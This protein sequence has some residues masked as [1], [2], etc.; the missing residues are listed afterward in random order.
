MT[1]QPKRLAALVGQLASRPGHETV[2][3]LTNELCVVGLDVPTQEVSFEVRIPEVR[4]RM[5]ALFGS[6]VF[7]FKRDLRKEKDDAEEQLARYISER[8]SS[9]KR[10]YLGIAT[11]GADFVAYQLTE[12]KL[13]RL[14]DFQSNAN[15]PRALLQWLDTAITVRGD[16]P[17]DTIT[18]RREFG[19][20]GLVFARA[21]E[22]LR[23]LWNVAK[24]IPEAAL[25]RELWH[26][27]LE[28]VYGTLVEPDPLFLQHTYLT[29]VAKAM[30]VQVLADRP[31]SAQDLLA[32]TPFVQVGLR[33]AVETDFFDWL[34]LAPGGEDLVNRIAGQVARFRLSEIDTDVLKTIY[35][36]LIDPQQ[37]HY[38]G[39]YYTPD[40]LAEWMCD[41]SVSEPLEQR[42]LDPACGSGTF[43]F[44]AVRRFLGA[45][46]RKGVL[47]Q[48]AL[49]SCTEHVI[50]IDVHPVAVLFARVTYLLAIGT[51]RLSKRTDDLFVPIYLG[52][53]LQWDVREFLTEKE[54]EIFVPG[55]KPLR[56]PGAVAADPHLLEK[57]L[58]AMREMSDQNASAWAFLT[59]LNAN[60]QIP[61]V[62]R[63]ILKE[64]FE[65]M[66]S[67]H[68]A[69][70][71]HIWTYVVR[72]LT[73]PLWLSMRVSK[74]DVVI[75][76]PPWL[77]FNA[78]SDN[79]QARFRRACENRN[80]WVGG[81]VAT[82]QDLSAYFFVR[83]AE[84]YLAVGGAIAFV[85]PMAALSRLQYRDFLTGSY[86]SARDTTGLYVQFKEAWKFDE[87][88]EPLFPVPSAVLFGRRGAQAAPLPAELIAFGGHLPSRDASSAQARRVLTRRTEPWPAL[89]AADNARASHY[90]KLFK[91]GATIVPRRLSIVSVAQGGRLGAN[92]AAPLVESR[93]SAI[94]KRPWKSLAP[95]KGQVEA[96]FLNTV[97]L[98]ESIA[99][100]RVLS[101]CTAVLSWSNDQHK[102]LTGDEALDAG[103]PYLSRWLRTAEQLW[104]KY[105][106]SD[107]SLT[108]RIDYFSGL[109]CQYPI[110]KYR[111]VYAKA[112]INPAAC[113][114][115]DIETV[116]DHK[117]YWCP[118]DTLGAAHYLS[119][120]LN[121]E[122]VRARI[123][124][125]QSRG[126]FGA[127]DF[128]KLMLG[129]PI[130]KFASKNAA[131]Q[132]LAELGKR[133]EDAAMG[134]EI[135][136]KAK[137]QKAR[138]LIREQLVELGI[139]Q[140]I[141]RRVKELLRA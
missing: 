8:E 119:C 94:D 50:G 98:G 70:R 129:L 27:H 10:R 71:N 133:A 51:D 134:V 83:S 6:T 60:T 122:H 92:K 63:Q 25:K 31:A 18:I 34:L 68:Q 74:P 126:Q 131:H 140:E 113:V 123:A 88:V 104:D 121:S 97:L 108:E 118:T 20:D 24:N 73:R 3:A 12:G 22:E 56:F 33:G 120:F 128:D 30:A 105:K 93:A 84:K 57:V 46:E 21:S 44:H 48:E 138:K 32:G 35:E 65:H 69:G 89:G 130:P 103:Y 100:F 112:G 67:L 76:N 38:L 47:L 41:H 29:I 125:R 54:I 115:R 55:E 39:E 107:M 96:E 127:R 136:E 82:H 78:M 15:D 52:D 141:D 117:L 61:D 42:V 66:R 37:R 72:N 139:S 79:M 17:P 90:K 5:D 101:A 132:A 26:Q 2:R 95:L 19:R 62:D 109:S 43:L 36:S 23:R 77:R 135:P 111:V 45:A 16:L 86:V 49:D 13:T 53:S 87:E 1:I 59:W 81:K 102:L 7:E 116:I 99:P 85:M 137:F 91:Q 124:G 110:A 106:T 28:F 4:G 58:T 14:R 75:G 9:T 11:D 64:S 40:W 80:I 114:I